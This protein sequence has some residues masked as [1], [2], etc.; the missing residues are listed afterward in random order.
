MAPPWGGGILMV[1]IG[2]LMAAG[3]HLLTPF[4]VFRDHPTA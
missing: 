3:L 4:D 2:T 1:V